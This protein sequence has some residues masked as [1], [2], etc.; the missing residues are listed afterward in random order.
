M[1]VIYTNILTVCSL[2][3]LSACGGGDTQRVAQTE[4]PQGWHFRLSDRK[5][6]ETPNV[7][8]RVFPEGVPLNAANTAEKR[9]SYFVLRKGLYRIGISGGGTLA[10][11]MLR[12][13]EGQEIEVLGSD[14]LPDCLSNNRNLSLSPAADALRYNNAQYIDCT[15]RIEQGA[16]QT[17]M[18]IL[19]YDVANEYGFEVYRCTDCF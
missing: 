5:T 17:A 11:L 8:K 13:G 12:V 7:C 18:L 6:G 2:F 15:I 16:K 19:E 3:L 10:S 9:R 1:Q 14:Q 4:P